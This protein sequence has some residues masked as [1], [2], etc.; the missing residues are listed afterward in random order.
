MKRQ[1]IS[2]IVKLMVHRRD[3]WK[4]NHC[5]RT[6]KEVKLHVD[7]INPVSRGGKTTWDNLQTLCMNCNCSKG[8]RFV[9]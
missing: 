8:A 7:H 3:A 2:P 1:Y 6:D 9:G 4:C 5:G